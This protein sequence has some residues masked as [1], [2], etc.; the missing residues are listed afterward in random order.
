MSKL[1]ASSGA[2]GAESWTTRTTARSVKFSSS[3]TGTGSAVTGVHAGSGWRVL[4]GRA[5]VGGTRLIPA[6]RLDNA[7]VAMVSALAG[8]M[9]G[10]QCRHHGSF[11]KIRNSCSGP[12]VVLR[13]E[14]GAW[15]VAVLGG[16]RGGLAVRDVDHSGSRRP[17]GPDGQ[18]CL[19]P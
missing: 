2:D 5:G 14:P 8:L 3:R 1:P 9:A 18:G 10:H 4:L 6:G 7:P 11:G 17:E 19:P 15:V 13:P 16:H 12:A